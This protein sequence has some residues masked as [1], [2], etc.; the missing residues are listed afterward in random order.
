MTTTGAENANRNDADK[1]AGNCSSGAVLGNG[2]RSF[3][4]AAGAGQHVARG[5]VVG[6]LSHEITNAQALLGNM[7][8]L[9][10][11]DADL[12]ASTVEGETQLVDVMQRGLARVLEL[13]GMLDGIAGMI[14]SLKDRGERLETQRDRIK[15]LLSVA[16]QTAGMKRLES[17]LATV[18]LRAVA[19]SVVVTSESD[20]PSR[21]WKPQEPKLDKRELLKALKDG[22]IAGAQLSNGG[23]TISI[24]V[25]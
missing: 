15:E 17:P 22:A 13:N 23:Q 9:L 3:A 16:M 11:D 19:P 14:A 1:G 25:D 6:D 8:D 2:N 12:I 21:F 10:G 18:S 20:I 4:D 24:K 5:N 7:R